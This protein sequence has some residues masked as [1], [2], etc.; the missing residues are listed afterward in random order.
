MGEAAEKLSGK[1]GIDTTDFKTGLSAANRELRVLESGFKASAA[2]LGDWTQS[3]TGLELRI[4][5]LTSQIDV[6]RLKVAAVREEYERLKAQN[7]ENSR[8]AQDA[9]IKLNNETASLAKMENELSTTEQTL[10]EFGEA[11]NKAGDNADDASGKV[12]NFSGVLSGIGTVVKGAITFVSA[13]A[14]AVGAVGGAITGLVLDTASASAELVDLSAKTGISTTRLQE[15]AYVG[16]QVGTSQETITGSLARLTRSMSSAQQ[17]T[18]DYAT[19]QA[20]AVAA[21]EE[22]DGTLGDNAA[23]F[24]TLGVS[25][26]DANGNL[27]DSE[28]VFADA[29]TALGGIN[30]EAERDALAISIFGKSA[31]E[32]SPLIKA[33]AD[34]IANLSD[35]AHEVGAVMSEEDVAAF[36][37]FD[38]SLS[39]MKMGLQGTLGTLAGAF[40]PGFQEVLG[41]AGGYLKDFRGIVDGSGGDIG[42]IAQGVGGLISTIIADV[43]AQAPQ[44]M[45][46]GVTIL[47][48]IID[49]IVANLPAMI[50]AG[51]DMLLTL[52][53]GL[54]SALPAIVE[55]ALLAIVALANGLTQALPTLIPT[56]TEV[57]AQIVLILVENLPMLIDAALQLILALATGLIA[58]LPILIPY[59]PQIV[60]AVFDALIQAYPLI[61]DAAVQLMATLT[62]GIIQSIPSLLLAAVEVFGSLYRYW[63]TEAPEMFKKVGLGIVDGIWSG[64]KNNWAT[65]KE[66]FNGLLGDLVASVKDALDMHSPS[67]VGEDIGDN[68]TGSIGSGAEKK[69]PTVRQQFERMA[70]SLTDN[71]Q[72]SMAPTVNAGG[73]QFAAAGTGGVNIGDIYVDARGATNPKAVGNAVAESILDKLRSYG[74]G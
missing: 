32:L 60:Q 68:F 55:A 1:I 33:G 64:I 61:M 72:M 36:E 21:G 9:E 49:A 20:Q 27:R 4:K 28:A 42:K 13:L 26:T 18:G 40:L 57:V 74:G 14:I 6:Q 12:N 58:A 25:V 65:L 50:T 70:R 46:T 5:S 2:S 35:K 67:G 19:A 56:I 3:A 73:L 17:Q 16:E 43:A 29:I 24:Q 37:E 11:E 41:Q 59:I 10:N 53:D 38:D 7:G 45:Q 23:A 8:A 54:V 22:F 51:V 39:S 34:E 63:T 48:S 66:S 69:A 31:M 71:L 44:L 62:N 47:T 30:N 52:V 15:L